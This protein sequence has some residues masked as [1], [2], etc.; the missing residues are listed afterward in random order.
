M[1]EKFGI[2]GFPTVLV[3][4]ADGKEMAR[5]GYQPGGAKA[6]VEHLKA[7]V[8]QPKKTV[9]K[10]SKADKSAEEKK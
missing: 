4:D 8:G 5:T 9:D 7:L 10:E 1:A 2:E 6:Y 3:L